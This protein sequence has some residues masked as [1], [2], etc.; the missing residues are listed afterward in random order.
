MAHNRKY[1][2][3]SIDLIRGRVL[4]DQWDQDAI[5]QLI[6]DSGMLKNAPFRWVGLIYRYG[7]KNMLIPEY[8]RIS[9]KWGDIPVA[10]ELKMEILEWADMNNIKLLYD[11]FMIGA[12]DVI[13]HIGKKYK[14]PIDLIEQER[15]KFR[16]IPETIEDCISYPAA[17]IE[18]YKFLKERFKIEINLCANCGAVKA[19]PKARQCLKCGEFYDPKLV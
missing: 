10:I 19:T 5:E 11:I 13:I 9:K 18:D 12:L 3:G 6:I 4:H 2:P 16:Q 8:Q 1:V 17:T 15:Q 7:I 14:L